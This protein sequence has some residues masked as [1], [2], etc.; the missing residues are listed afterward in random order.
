MATLVTKLHERMLMVNIPVACKYSLTTLSQ[1]NASNSYFFKSQVRETKIYAI[2]D[3]AVL[4]RNNFNLLKYQV[5]Y[6]FKKKGVVLRL[7]FPS[8]RT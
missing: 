8:S 4:M 5:S 6:L 3:R 1:C 7:C 2:S